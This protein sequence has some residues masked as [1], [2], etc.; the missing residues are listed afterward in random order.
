MDDNGHMKSDVEAAF[1]PTSAEVRS[2][3]MIGG[4]KRFTVSMLLALVSRDQY[5]L[6]AFRA[7]TLPCEE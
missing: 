3:A 6:R 7:V 1:E 5:P 2:L 4:P